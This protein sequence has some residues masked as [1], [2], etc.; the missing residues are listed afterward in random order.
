MCGPSASR[1]LTEGLL[2]GRHDHEPQTAEMGYL[3]R[4]E[5]RCVHQV[6]NQ[7]RPSKKLPEAFS[8]NKSPD[9]ARGG[10]ITKCATSKGKKCDNHWVWKERRHFQHVDML[11]PPMAELRAP[12]AGHGIFQI[13]AEVKDILHGPFPLWLRVCGSAMQ[14]KRL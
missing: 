13:L 9:L 11:H 7:M 10:F 14:N 8:Q 12:Q 2:A 1:S 5:D 3:R 4:M 6:A